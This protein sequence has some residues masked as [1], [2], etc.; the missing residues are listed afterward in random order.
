MPTRTEKGSAS[1]VLSETSP[2]SG[3]V[4]A[5]AELRDS[6]RLTG[7]NILLRGAGAVIDVALGNIDPDRVE[8]AWRHRA[9]EI[10]AEIGWHGS[11]PQARRFPGGMSIGFNAPIDALYAATEV[12]EWAW[13]AACADLGAAGEHILSADLE[14]PETAAARLRAVIAAESN[15]D[16]IRL[17]DAAREHGVTFLSDDDHASV[18]LGSG[19]R[20]WPVRDIPDP[21][22][23]EWSDIH[24]IPVVLVT[25]TNGKTTSVRLLAAMARAAGLIPGNSSTD[26]I[27]VGGVLVEAGDWSGPG[28]GRAVLRD[29]RVQLAILESARGGMARRGLALPHA[30]A[31]IVTNVAADHLG[32]FGVHDVDGLARLKLVVGHAV[33]PTG[34][35]ILNAD[36]PVLARNADR[37][38]AGKLL[39]APFAW[40]GLGDEVATLASRPD[41]A[42]EV[43]TVRDGTFVFL[44]AGERALEV[45]VADVPITLGGAAR[46]NVYNCLGAIAGAAALSIPLPAVDGAL[47]EF[48]G[49][50]ADNPGRGNEYNLGGVRVFQDFAHNPHGMEAL[51]GMMKALP[52]KR[53]LIILGQGGDRDDESIRELAR[54]AW[55][56]HPDHVIVKELKKYLRGR[57]PGEVPAIIEAALLEAGAP[58]EA[59][60]RADSEMEAVSRALMW[61]EPGDLVLLIVHGRQ[62]EATELLSRLAERGWKPGQ[63]LE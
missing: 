3:T 19:S 13:E 33:P 50:A 57:S 22:R 35:I 49:S 6:R 36:D 14:P 30:D 28:G 18:G 38:R 61:S 62:S 1:R 51:A 39:R 25:G 32:E 43:A 7:P 58:P 37:V 4:S 2:S 52:G 27:Y 59:I 26:G 10:L 8:S 56:A 21:E 23:L 55:S 42:A 41:A 20:C 17:R 34:R 15:P 54:T 24:D 44:R 47:R 12:N 46:H 40:F 29:R 63:E 48:E 11:R 31:A 45:P 5:A 53:R 16:L 9:A 60:E